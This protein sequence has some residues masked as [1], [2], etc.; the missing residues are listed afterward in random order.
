VLAERTTSLFHVCELVLILKEELAA[1]IASG[2]CHI[3]HHVFVVLA[4]P[5]GAKLRVVNN[6]DILIPHTL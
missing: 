5:L 1:T 3:G 4:G 2:H 6:E